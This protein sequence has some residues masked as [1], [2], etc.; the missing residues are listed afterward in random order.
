MKNTFVVFIYKESLDSKE[1]TSIGENLTMPEA[2]KLK[3]SNL[4][5]EIMSQLSWN[6]LGESFVVYSDLEDGRLRMHASY[7]S[8]SD[9]QSLL[10]HADYVKCGV[11]PKS[12]WDKLKACPNNPDWL[13]FK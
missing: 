4:D 10:R 6:D 2:I 9:A 13:K 7:E 12:S 8:S 5:S 3:D 1:Y 11:M